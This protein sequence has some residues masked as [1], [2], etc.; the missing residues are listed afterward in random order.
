[1]DTFTEHPQHSEYKISMS[2]KVLG[3]R[4]KEIG[5]TRPDGYRVVWI[6]KA[7]RFE[8]VH[9]LVW[10]TY[11]GH[12][13]ERLEINHLDGI[14]SNNE[15]FNLDAVTHGANASHSYQ[16]LARERYAGTD[17]PD[18]GTKASK[19]TKELMSAKKIGALHPKFKGWYVIDGVEYDSSYSAGKALNISYKIVLRRVKSGLYG[20]RPE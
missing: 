15:L 2:G 19:E 7:G 4:G 10:Q 8:Y 9:R 1:M 11:I 13:V 20:F 6:S 12:I 16:V 5:S 18:Y 3:P 17:S 14:R